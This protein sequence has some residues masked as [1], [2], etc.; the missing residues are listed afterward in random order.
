[1]FFLFF[2]LFAN[3]SLSLLD[4]DYHPLPLS[5]LSVA[6]RRP[7]TSSL[8]LSLC[9]SHCLLCPLS[10]YISVS[11]NIFLFFGCVSVS[12]P[13]CLTFDLLGRVWLCHCSSDKHHGSH[14]DC[15]CD[16]DDGYGSRVGSQKPVRRDREAV[17]ET[18]KETETQ[19]EIETET[20][21]NRESEL[22]CSLSFLF[23]MGTFLY[24][25][26]AL[27]RLPRVS[28]HSQVHLLILSL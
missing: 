20:A 16:R 13:L 6:V 7:G 2:C 18:E 4:C 1:M 15:H 19:T 14:R 27:P 28:S 25:P 22:L 8:P 21:R 26:F 9:L 3:R 10:L 23:Q 11:V 12:R 17:M 5:S 24:I